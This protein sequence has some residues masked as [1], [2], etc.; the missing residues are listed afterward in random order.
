MIMDALQ[1]ITRHFDIEETKR[2][3]HELGQ[4]IRDEPDI[5]TGTNVQEYPSLQKID[6]GLAN[7]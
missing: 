2:Q 1:Q 6:A 3:S 4:K 7:E 5:D